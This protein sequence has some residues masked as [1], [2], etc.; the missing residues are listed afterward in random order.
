MTFTRD[1]NW[2]Q[3][4]TDIAKAASQKLSF[5]FRDRQYFSSSNLFT[6]YKAQIRPCL[7][8]CSHIWGAAPPTTLKILDSIQRRSIRLINDPTLT[9]TLPILAHRLAVG[10]LSLFY[11]YFNG[12]CSEELKSIVPPLERPQRIN[13]HSTAMHSHSVQLPK[14]RTSQFNRYFIPRTAILWNSLPKHIFPSSPNLHIF[15]SGVNKL[16]L[17]S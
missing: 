1:M 6:L 14:S 4:V 5:L 8:Y 17:S 12:R 9:A 3:H 11:R 15:K 2:H 10:D 7:E 16:K 13:R